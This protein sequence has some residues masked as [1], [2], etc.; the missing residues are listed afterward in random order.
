MMAG[1]IDVLGVANCV[2][3]ALA[4]AVVPAALGLALS[5]AGA[6]AVTHPAQESVTPTS[7]VTDAYDD[8][9]TG[10]N[11][12]ETTLTSA[13]VAGLKEL[14]SAY[15]P[16]GMNAQPVEAAGIDVSGTPTNIVYQG[17]N[18]GWFYA[19]SAANG[20]LIWRRK[21]HQPAPALSKSCTIARSPPRMFRR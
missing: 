19:L 8:Q 3:R 12:D 17:T 2:R 20:S 13:N 21:S 14:W 18:S 7:V 15:V 16:G 9:R 6:R 11:P 1:K 5:A 10:F 4:L